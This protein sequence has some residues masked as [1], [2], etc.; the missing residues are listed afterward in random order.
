MEKKDF[1]KGTLGY[2]IEEYFNEEMKNKVEIAYLI[3]GNKCDSYE[4]A[5]TSLYYITLY[6]G[7]EGDAQFWKGARVAVANTNTRLVDIKEKI[8]KKMKT[9]E[10]DLMEIINDMPNMKRVFDFKPQTLKQVENED[11]IN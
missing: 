3:R 9:E 2:C 10:Q 1:K 11:E 5:L 6:T 7:F 4:E 8:E